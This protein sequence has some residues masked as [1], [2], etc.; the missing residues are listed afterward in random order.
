MLTEGIGDLLPMKLII[1]FLLF[2]LVYTSYGQ[3][4]NRSAFDEV[5]PIF[6]TDRITAD[7]NLDEPIWQEAGMITNLWQQFPLDSVKAEGQTE[8]KMAYDEDFLYVAVRS[9][10]E[11]DQFIVPSLKRDF[12]FQGNDNIT[13]LFDTY[14]DQ[15]NAFVFGMNAYGVRREALVSNGGRQSGDFQSSWDNKWN[16]NASRH[17]DYWIAEFA[18]PFKTFRFNEGATEWRFNIYRNDTQFNERSTWKRIPQNR[19]IMDLSYMGKVIWPK[20]LG[21]P[22]RNISIIPYGT[23]GIARDFENLEQNSADF[24]ADVGFDAKLAVTSG[25]NLDLTV[26]PDFSQVEVDQQVTNLDRFEIFFPER[27]QFFLENADLFGS[28]GLSRVNPFFSRRIGV[29]R[30]TTTGQNFQNPIHYGVRL[31]GKVNDRLR[32]GMLNMQ[33]AKE[34]DNGLPSFNY[35]VAALQQRVFNR[36]NIS[37]IFANKQSINPSE[38]GGDFNDYNRVAG[39]EYRL[40]TNS[41]RWIGKAFYHQSFSPENLDHNFT[42]GAQLEYQ[43]RKY[44]FEWAHVMIGNG[45]EAEVGFVP[46]KDYLLLSP[47]FQIFFYP[48]SG[49]INRHSFNMDTRIFFQIGKDGNQFIDDWGIGERQFEFTWDFQFTNNTQGSI[50]S[51]VN[52]I[53]LL[54]DFDPTRVQED[55]VFLPAGETYNFTDLSL[56]YESDQR[57]TVFFSLEPTIGQFY[58]GFRTG[59]EGD[60]TY[61]FQPYGSVTFNFNYNRIDLEAPFKTA[62][63]WL[64]GPRIDVTFS[65]KLFWT[66]FFQYNN[67]LDNLNINARFQWR[68]APVS[69]FFLVYTDNYLVDTFSNF[70]KRNRAVVAKLTYWL[71]I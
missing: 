39:L 17:E 57:K 58:N 60:V 18:I 5:H 46:R 12:S 2:V 6:T 68:F 9:N 16:G 66:T 25:L 28:F 42:Q 30:D 38:S 14:N 52:E 71:N 23:T 3:N 8:I 49:I 65:K 32:I 21:K 15:T 48:S 33:T 31:S 56:N 64:L 1:V 7:G 37:F 59:V 43:R 50:Q 4:G 41:N 10:A 13:I 40:F 47:E 29:A 20:P 36:S 54:N 45:F 11:N 24:D 53:T 61:R 44:R 67:Q 22:G 62:D 55:T 26:N 34:S 63:V 51:T 70:Q 35:T 27:R 19:L 69:D